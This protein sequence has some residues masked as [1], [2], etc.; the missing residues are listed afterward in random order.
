[1]NVEVHGFIEPGGF[2][3]R[4]GSRHNTS[5]AEGQSSPY[6][7]FGPSSG[8]S[9]SSTGDA[10]RC[11]R[12]SRAHRTSNATGCHQGYPKAQQQPAEDVKESD[13]SGATEV[14]AGKLA[15]FQDAPEIVEA[16]LPEAEVAS[17][18]A[19]APTAEETSGNVA[20]LTEG[21]SF[22]EEAEVAQPASIE[23]KI[24]V[25]NAKFIGD[26]S[27]PDGTPLPPAAEF[28]KIWSL[29]NTGD[30]IPA[31]TRVIFVGGENFSHEAGE[32][33]IKEDVVVGARFLV[34][35]AGLRAPKGAEKNHTGFWRLMDSEGQVFG[36]RLWVE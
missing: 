2:T 29:E 27:I 31:G 14:A 8:R 4:R 9:G 34:T 36:D 20:P 30:M 33:Q 1:M 3:H 25:M 11:G 28:T 16:L 23:T 17:E 26:V 15:S 24:P 22:A 35:L 21:I 18:E 10:G 7:H 5:G 6:G 12:R 19:L 13:V 32:A